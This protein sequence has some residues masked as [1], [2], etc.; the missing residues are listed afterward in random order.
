MTN[1]NYYPEHRSGCSLKRDSLIDPYRMYI[2]SFTRG[3]E[4]IQL[5]CGF[6]G[7]PGIAS[8]FQ[9]FTIDNEIDYNSFNSL[10]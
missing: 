8:Q 3:A 2:S 5:I 7:I 1:I 10:N 9:L 6:K 4:E